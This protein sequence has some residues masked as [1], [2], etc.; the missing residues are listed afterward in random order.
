MDPEHVGLKV[1]SPYVFLEVGSRRNLLI[2]G[3]ND[4]QESLGLTIMDL[5]CLLKVL[6]LQAESVFYGSKLD[7][8]LS[9]TS[10]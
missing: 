4:E 3:G 1:M 8:V 2:D 7:Y 6:A 10:V 9:Q 5:L